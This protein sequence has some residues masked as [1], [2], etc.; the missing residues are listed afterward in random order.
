M[1]R[2]RAVSFARTFRRIPPLTNRFWSK[3]DVKGFFDC[4]NW[5]AG[6]GRLQL[7][8]RKRVTVRFGIKVGIILRQG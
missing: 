8:I 6:I 3:V 2:T 4:W 5:T 1:S 7:E